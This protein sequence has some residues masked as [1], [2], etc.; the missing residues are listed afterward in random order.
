Q[1]V[2]DG[3][4]NKV[5][6]IQTPGAMTFHGRGHYDVDQIR[7]K[8]YYAWIPKMNYDRLGN[9]YHNPAVSSRIE[10][11]ITLAEGEHAG[12]IKRV[13]ELLNIP[14]EKGLVRLHVVARGGVSSGCNRL[15]AGHMWELRNIFP[16]SPK[17][18]AQVK[19]RGSNS[20]D[21]D[22]FD[23]DGDGTLEVM[24]VKYYIAYSLA[25]A[26]ASTIFKD[27]TTGKA[28]VPKRNAGAY[29]GQSFNRVRFLTHLLGANQIKLNS[30]TKVVSLIDPSYSL[31]GAKRVN[32]R[33]S[34]SRTRFAIDKPFS[35]SLKG[36]YKMYEQT[37]D[38]DKLQFYKMNKRSMFK[39][40][41]SEK[42]SDHTN[43]G[44]FFVRTLGRIVGCGP[45]TDE[46]CW[47]SSFD[48]ELKSSLSYVK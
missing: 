30:D 16:S 29:T 17:R 42:G 32:Q 45:Y 6:R 36:E 37:Y 21:Y 27:P 23:I 14:D 48:Q 9:G 13:R 38:Q 47:E 46:Y 31:F 34:Y 22:L 28:E 18:M 40:L 20:K 33:D 15:A 5:P 7:G 12:S 3:E 35:V 11:K 41:A 10:T 43:Q 19:Y 25:K 1:Y 39:S 26:G 2:N 24:G 4:G 44:K 8:T